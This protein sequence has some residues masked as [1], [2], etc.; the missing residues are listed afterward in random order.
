[1]SGAGISLSLGLGGGKTSTATAGSGSGGGGGGS[2]FNIDILATKAVILAR[3]GDEV[4]VIAFVTTGDNQ[5]DIMVFDGTNWQI[6]YN[7]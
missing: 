7:A 4:G 5:Y 6:Y 1:M 2:G 3:T